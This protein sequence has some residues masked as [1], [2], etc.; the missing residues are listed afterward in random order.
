MDVLPVDKW[1]NQS[2]DPEVYANTSTEINVGIIEF[3]RMIVFLLCL[4]REENS[5]NKIGWMCFYV[6][7]NLDLCFLN[8]WPC[9]MTN[10]F[11]HLKCHNNNTISW[12]GKFAGHV[13][14]GHVPEKKKKKKAQW[15]QG[16]G[17][18]I[19][20]A[21]RL[22]TVFPDGKDTLYQAMLKFLLFTLLLQ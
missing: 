3:L 11:I 22:W 4:R 15:D 14:V 10:I 1:L 21:C 17:A 13:T 8:S 12:R 19:S 16:C 7:E 6:F 5:R 2:T 9:N 20:A 18:W